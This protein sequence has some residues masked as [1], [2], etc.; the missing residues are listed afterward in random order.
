MTKKIEVK[1]HYH[2]NTKGEMEPD[3]ETTSEEFEAKLQ[4]I[5]E[6]IEMFWHCL[7]YTS[8]SPRDS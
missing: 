7:L 6:K 1:V 2:Q 3:W 4:E 8:P 5:D